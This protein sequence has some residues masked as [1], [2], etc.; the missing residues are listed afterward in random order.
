MTEKEK[1]LSGRPW[2]HDEEFSKAFN[3]TQELLFDLNTLRPSEV[4][5]RNKIIKTI[6]GKIGDKFNIRS[7]FYCI[8][9]RY[10][11]VGENF[12]ANFNCIIIDGAKVTIGDNVMFGPNVRLFTG[13]HPLHH[14]RREFCCSFP[15]TIGN[16][17]WIGGGA[18][19]NSNITIGDNTVIGSGSVVTKNI[20]PNVIAAGNPCQVIREITDDDRQYY[21]KKMRFEDAL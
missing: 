7:P 12:F 21:F 2:K 19:V 3:F 14:E 18:I 8:F 5:E 6:F 4:E 9:G 20:P 15:I 1:M 11:L 13:G 10:I 17:V 16:N